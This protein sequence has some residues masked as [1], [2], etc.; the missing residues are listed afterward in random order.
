MTV[1][2]NKVLVAAFQAHSHRLDTLKRQGRHCNIQFSVLVKELIP[3]M[4][5]HGYVS[6][7][8]VAHLIL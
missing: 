3:I 6:F 5:G 2:N 1:Q 7:R 8:C 4:A